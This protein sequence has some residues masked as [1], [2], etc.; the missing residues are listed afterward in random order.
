MALDSDAQF[1]AVAEQRLIP[2]RAR[3]ISCA[4]LVCSLF[5]VPACQCQIPG[6]HAGVGLSGCTLRLLV[7]FSFS[8]EF[9]EFFRLGQ[10]M[11][12]TIPAGAGCVVHMFVV[13]GHHR[14]E[15]DPEK[16]T[17]TDRLL[18]AVLAE[19]QVVCVCQHCA[20]TLV[21]LVLCVFGTC[22]AFLVL[23]EVFFSHGVL[24]SIFRVHP[25]LFALG[26]LTHVCAVS[27][28]DFDVTRCTPCSETVLRPSS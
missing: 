3:C 28:F 9:K 26:P 7:V 20:H 25:C 6:V 21:V 13:Y 17:L 24:V 4:E 14:A 23:A 16:L 12:V 15:E 5:W 1:M 11:R 8:L 10:A 19:T 27:S 18:G 22:R 2:A